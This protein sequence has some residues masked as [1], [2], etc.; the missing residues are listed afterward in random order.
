MSNR[1]RIDAGEPGML[2]RSKGEASADPPPG[3]TLP[4]IF[5]FVDRD[6]LVSDLSEMVEIPS[7]NPFDNGAR[8]GY[9]ELEMAEFYLDRMSG[10]GMTVGS[11]EVAPGRPNVWGILKGK[12]DGSSLMLSGHLDTV[13]IENYDD[14]LRAKIADGRVYGRGSCD[15]KAGLAAYL[16]VVRLL[17]ETDTSLKGD[18]VITGLADEEHLMIGSRDMGKHGPW[19]AYG[20]IGEPSNLVIC[21]GHKGQLGFRIR[22]LGKAVHSSQPE[23][24]INAIEAMARVI[25][26]FREYGAEL[27][28]RSAHPLCGHA[29]SCPGVIRGGTIVSTVP[30]FCELEIDR[31]T[32]PGETTECVIEEYR[33]LLDALAK[34]SP[35]FRY[36]I[37]GP[38][39]SIAPLDIP[40]DSPIVKSVTGGYESVVSKKATV[41][42]FLGGTDAP[43]LGFPALVF[44]PGGIAQAHS[45]N[46][47][48]EIDDMVAATKIYLWTALDLL[49]TQP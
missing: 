28:K 12:G 32:L 1:S 21:P 40:L 23:K 48:V 17:R 22:T 3:E 7:V 46:E 11:R 37:A 8:P 15:M 30:D 29:R 47:F 45:I 18:L 27:M 10:L 31:R 35:G 49:A 9:R 24:G 25:E 44:G 26:A 13:G 14:A 19:A 4:P 33:H 38:T 6:R 34:S 16:E 2:N 5:D 42:A 39:L 41:S 43:N 20:I 36:E